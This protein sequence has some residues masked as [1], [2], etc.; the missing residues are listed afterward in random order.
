VWIENG[1][2]KVKR[3]HL[4]SRGE[5]LDEWPE[6]FFDERLQEILGWSDDI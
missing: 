6:G 5:F 3:I 2:S 4:N 1:S